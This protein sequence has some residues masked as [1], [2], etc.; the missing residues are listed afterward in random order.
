MYY[1]YKINTIKCYGNN[2]LIHYYGNK[3]KYAIE[4]YLSN[5]HITIAIE[6]WCMAIAIEIKYI[7][8]VITIQFMT[9]LIKIRC[10][11]VVIDV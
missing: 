9:T 11:A 7:V 4:C 2:K 10:V 1:C 5:R 3:N 6:I 8:I